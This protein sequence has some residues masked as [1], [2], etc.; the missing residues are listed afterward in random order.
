MRHRKSRDEDARWGF[1][2]AISSFWGEIS[3]HSSHDLGYDFNPKISGML[4]QVPV[5]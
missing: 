2:S 4:G 3:L 5:R 1:N